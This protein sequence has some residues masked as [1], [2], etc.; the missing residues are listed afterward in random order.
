MTDNWLAMAIVGGVFLL[1]GIVGIIW[2]RR[3][4]AEDYHILISHADVRTDA[5]KIVQN[6]QANSGAGALIIGGL[7]SITIG[8]FLLILFAIHLYQG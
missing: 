3:E 6:W 4:A 7:I 1:V 5:K 8:L 2:G